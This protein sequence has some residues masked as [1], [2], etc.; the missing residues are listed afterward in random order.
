MVYALKRKPVIK[1]LIVP[2]CMCRNG[3]CI[4]TTLIHCNCIFHCIDGLS[5]F[6]KWVSWR[7]LKT[8]EWGGN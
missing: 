8:P 7:W 1:R 5:Q 4:T 3:I 2:R 6:L